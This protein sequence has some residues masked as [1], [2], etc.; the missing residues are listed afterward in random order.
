[1]YHQEPLAIWGILYG[2]NDAMEKTNLVNTLQECIKS[3]NFKCSMPRI[4]E[5]PSARPED[6]KTAIGNIYRPDI[7]CLLCLIPG[8]KMSNPLYNALKRFTLNEKPVPTQCV[9]AA[10]IKKGKNIRSILNR[11][12]MQ[13]CAKVGGIPWA[14][15]DVSFKNKPTMVCGLDI[16]HKTGSG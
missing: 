13:I 3:Y 1:M 7:A 6:W 5:V 15:T 11:V 12:L 9:L 4:V 16:G 8:N 2:R 14:I 10:T